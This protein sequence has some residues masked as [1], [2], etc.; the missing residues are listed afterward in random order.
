[1]FNKGLKKVD[2]L[3]QLK[4]KSSKSSSWWMYNFLIDRRKDF[5]KMLIKNHISFSAVNTRIDKNPIFQKYSSHLEMQNLF[6]KKQIS[7]S[8]DPSQNLDKVDKIINIIRKGW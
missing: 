3:T 8:T 4:Y 1:M 5:A 2:G 6:E 7:L